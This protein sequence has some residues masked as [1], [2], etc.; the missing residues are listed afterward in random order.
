M[1]DT[2]SVMRRLLRFKKDGEIRKKLYHLYFHLSSHRARTGSGQKSIP[3]IGLIA[4]KSGR[5]AYGSF[6]LFLL[7]V[8]IENRKGKIKLIL[9]LLNILILLKAPI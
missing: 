7:K 4:Q 3:V 6:F 1:Q 2:E 5:K 9:G 8:F